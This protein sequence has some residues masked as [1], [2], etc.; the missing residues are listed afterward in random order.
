MH[1]K[2]RQPNQAWLKFIVDVKINCNEEELNANYKGR[3]VIY[4][5]EK[6]KDVN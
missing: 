5:M 6:L 3:K 4:T 2:K 1:D